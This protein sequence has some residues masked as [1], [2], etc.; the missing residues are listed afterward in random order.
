M[1]VQWLNWRASLAICLAIGLIG[2]G[3]ESG[4]DG[5]MGADG[6]NALVK[7][8]VVPAG[9]NCVAGGNR[10]DAGLD[11]DGD[12][13]L[14]DSE[15]ATTTYVCHGEEGAPGQ[16]G[17][18]GEPGAPGESSEGC[19]GGDFSMTSVFLA[20]DEW[21]EFEYGQT[22]EVV[23]VFD[24]D[25]GD[26]TRFSV[27]GQVDRFD[28]GFERVAGSDVEFRAPWT[29]K[30]NIHAGVY[31]VIATDGCGI[32][33]GTFTLD[34][35]AWSRVRVELEA[36]KISLPLEGGDVELCWTS[37]NAVSCALDVESD[38]GSTAH[39]DGLAPE[40]CHTMSLYTP[41]NIY[42]WCDSEPD[43]YGNIKSSADSLFVGFGPLI[44][45]FKAVTPTILADGEDSVEFV[46]QAAFVEHCELFINDSSFA[47]DP[48]ASASD[49]YALIITENSSVF[50]M[51]TTDDDQTIESSRIWVAVGAYI[52]DF[53]FWDED[54]DEEEGVALVS[55]EA[56]LYNV[57]NC[58]H[59]M[60]RN[61]GDE[62]YEMVWVDEFLIWPDGYGYITGG[63]YF[64]GYN[65]NYDLV[66]SLICVD[67]SGDK[68][69][70]E[71]FILNPGPKAA[72]EI[73]GFPA[74]R[75]E[76][77]AEFYWT[78]SS[79]S[80]CVLVV[81]GDPQTV[82]IQ[83]SVDDP[84]KLF[85]DESSEIY[86]ECMQADEGPYTSNTVYVAVG[87]EFGEVDIEIQTNSNQVFRAEY[88][89]LVLFGN[90]CVGTVTN[91]SY[92][93]VL[94][95]PLVVDLGVS[96]PGVFMYSVSGTIEIDGGYDESEPVFMAMT[97]SDS[98]TGNGSS[99]TLTL[100]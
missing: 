34:E 26:N 75:E 62:T 4:A 18:P 71:E 57:D 28:E 5:E 33:V 84:L 52:G 63:V 69:T 70:K 13:E 97:C 93:T 99:F 41:A 73:I 23:V 91:G 88:S 64:D 14:Q 53:A 29:L 51:C 54:F 40:G 44:G 24:Q 98:T 61:G 30:P 80:D 58:K 86:L 27:M 90:Q 74:L 19:S 8:T 50:L 38:Y 15:I 9:E 67:E 37:R 16:A 49:P 25:P 22:Y 55:W 11:H 82:G 72:L 32:A 39:V 78:T 92:H 46:W 47:V 31:T 66:L 21:G 20:E 81:N 60:I 35:P 42:L 12:G 3:G 1:N 36:D 59:P 7:V 6:L 96:I 85:L 48:V 68:E 95:P 100:G 43:V 65:P 10:I 76:G 89:F 79:V 83:R 56:A 87:V 45:E 2:C 77:E 94:D 17:V